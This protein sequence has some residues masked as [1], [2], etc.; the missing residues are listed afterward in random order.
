MYCRAYTIDET[1][2]LKAIAIYQ[3][4]TKLDPRLTIAYTNEGNCHFRLKNTTEAQRLYELAL[5]MDPNQ[6]EALV[7]PS[8][9]ADPHVIA[10]RE[11]D[12]LC[13]FSYRSDY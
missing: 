5:S 1:E 6:P 12:N 10:G 4:A 7:A 3:A 13:H 2:P 8:L 9:M 11:L